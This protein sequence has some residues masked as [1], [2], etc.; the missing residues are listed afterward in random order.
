MLLT[1]I[2]AALRLDLFDPAGPNQRWTTMD[3]DRAIDKAVDRYSQY[4]PNIM[5]T[6][7]ATQPYQR[8]YPYPQSWNGSYP[9]WWLERIIYPLQVYGSAFPAPTA[10]PL[11]Q[12]NAG[13]GLNIGTYRYLV[14]WLTP[15]GETT[16]SPVVTV[17]TTSGNQTVLLSAIPFAS[18]LTSSGTNTVIG[19][20]LYRTQVNGQLFFLLGTIDDNTTTSWL[21]NLP[22][23]ALLNRAQ[24]PTINTSGIM[25]W[26]PRECAFAEYSNL[27]DSTTALAA[28]GNP[29]LQ[30]RTGSPSFTLTFNN[31]ELPKD[32]TQVIR[33]FYATRHQLDTSG[34]TIP[35]V[36]RDSIILGASVYAMEAYQVSTNDNF[37][38]QDGSLHDR[39]DDTQSPQAWLA[40]ITSR[41]QQF[42]ERLQEIK[43]QRDFAYAARIHWGEI[44]IHWGRL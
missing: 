17:T 12:A 43:Q 42:E 25:L 33:I 10:I 4:Y 7:M 8:T 40:A 9:V 34:S 37:E 16:P 44:P 11:A 35:E 23:S 3:L 6:D 19:R 30:G 29:D 31:A 39:I 32:N 27:F 5:Y 13:S 21:D 14:T 18:T 28:G 36:H 1:D 22:D 15:G 24:P 41:R 38:F 20:N 2:E 26:P